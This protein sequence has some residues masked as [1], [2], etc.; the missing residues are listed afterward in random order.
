MV[1]DQL[2]SHNSYFDGDGT[3]LQLCF[4]KRSFQ[5][6]G[7][8]VV[9]N[10]LPYLINRWTGEIF[11]PAPSVAIIEKE[12]VRAKESKRSG[13]TVNQVGRF[14]RGKFPVAV[15]TRFK[16]SVIE[17]FFIPG[18][19]RGIPSDGYLTPTYFNKD[20]LLKYEHSES[21][22]LDQTTPSA[23]SIQ[24]KGGETIPYGINQ[25]GS[26]VMW[27]GDIV[28]LSE[29][30]KQY[31]YSENIDPQYDLHSDFYNSQILGEWFGAI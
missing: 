19:L 12:V 26:V 6:A 2:S 15:G 16:Y 21:C 30:E 10:T 23:G 25:S 29:Q 7:V 11:F 14:S 5:Y 9:L 4:D 8:R 24:V 13:V 1:I 17:H 31:L 20:V 28:S 27:L 3:P 22:N 18:L